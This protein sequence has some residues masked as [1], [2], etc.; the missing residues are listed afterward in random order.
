MNILKSIIRIYTAY[1]A[2]A[3]AEADRK[4]FQSYMAERYRLPERIAKEN[5]YRPGQW[6]PKGG[7]LG[8][9]RR[10]DN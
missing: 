4:A 8:A 5:Q 3:A 7:G 2:K 6:R 10:I 1:K 9:I